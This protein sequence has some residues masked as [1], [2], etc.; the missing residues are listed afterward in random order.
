MYCTVH[1]NKLGILLFCKFEHNS[2]LCSRNFILFYLFLLV[3]H[4]SRILSSAVDHTVLAIN[5]MEVNSKFMANGKGEVEYL[6]N[7]VNYWVSIQFSQPCLTSNE[8]LMLAS[9]FHS[10]QV[11]GAG[12]SWASC[13]RI[14]S[15]KNL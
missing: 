3:M 8:K 5:G 4:D 13:N 15:L 7:P 12:R 14:S 10:D 6:G 11:C 1:S 9:M 2:K